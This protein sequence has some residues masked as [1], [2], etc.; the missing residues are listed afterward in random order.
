MSK[1]VDRQ[2]KGPLPANSQRGRTTI[3]DQAYT[4][5]A[6]G[7]LLTIPLNRNDYQYGILHAE[8]T[9]NPDFAR[10][11]RMGIQ[12]FFTTDFNDANARSEVQET[13]PLL[14]P[15]GV[16]ITFS[17]YSTTNWKT[18]AF[19][20]VEAGRISSNDFFDDRIVFESCRINGNQIEIRLLG[21]ASSNGSTVGLTV[22]W[23]VWR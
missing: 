23:R 3:P 7:M 5:G 13:E 12:I 1:I 4:G 17:S 14:T 16:E 10:F 11:E 18:K 21:I 22:D 2:N 19:F 20:Y 6:A 15:A 9:E 8:T